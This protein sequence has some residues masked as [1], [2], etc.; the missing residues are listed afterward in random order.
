MEETIENYHL[1]LDGLRATVED[2]IQNKKIKVIA[3]QEIKSKEVIEQVLGKFTGQF[4]ICV[5]PHNAFQTVAFAWNKS[6]PAGANR[7][8][9]NPENLPSPENSADKF[10]HRV[11]PGL[12]LELVINGL[13]VTFMNI[14]LKSGCAN[15]KT[16]PGFPGHKLY[17]PR[18]GLRGSQ[19]PDSHPGGL[20]R[21]NR[22]TKVL[23]SF[24]W[25]ILTAE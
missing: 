15:L 1:K 24:Y 7:C 22:P 8:T 21:A 2:L 13:P 11:R 17:R 10:A 25:E 14:H 19:P 18:A 4:D 3:F 6:I 16:A 23:V 20:G 5:A 9:T 12:A